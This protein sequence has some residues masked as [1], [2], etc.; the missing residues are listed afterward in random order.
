MGA[1]GKQLSQ[2]QSSRDG[3]IK[4]FWWAKKKGQ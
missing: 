2:P 4:S 1:N 3:Y